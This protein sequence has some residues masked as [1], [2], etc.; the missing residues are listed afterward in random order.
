MHAL[1]LSSGEWT[2]WRS[3]PV[4]RSWNFSLACGDGSG[5]ARATVTERWLAEGERE[6]RIVLQRC[7][8][9]EYC[10]LMVNIRAG[11]LLPTQ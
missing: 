4:D 8:P 5:D 2:H 7:C 6:A 9:A 11:A 10:H 1:G 3:T